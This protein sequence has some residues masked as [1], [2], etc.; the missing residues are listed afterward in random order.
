MSCDYQISTDDAVAFNTRMATSIGWGWALEIMARRHP[1]PNLRRLVDAYVRHGV[2]SDQFLDAVLGYQLTHGLVADRK[3]GNA[4]WRHA[5]QTNSP[6]VGVAVGGFNFPLCDKTILVD[7]DTYQLPSVRR[8]R[9]TFDLVVLHWGGFDPESC[10]AALAN[11]DLSTHFVVR[12]YPSETDQF[13]VYQTADLAHTALHVGNYNSRSVGIDIARSPL[14][15]FAYKYPN[16]PP[17]PNPTSRGEREVVPLPA[18]YA[19]GVWRFA[20]QVALLLDIPVGDYPGDSALS[21]AA[22]TDHRGIVGHHHLSSTK[23]DVAPWSRAIWPGNR[24]GS[25]V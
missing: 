24:I 15:R 23:W 5:C 10:V 18:E 12:G 13:W 8:G 14:T 6:A 4:S 19:E 9:S 21:R 3:L 25:G 11:R 7:Q 17:E 20:E 22:R 16:T 2:E 1:P